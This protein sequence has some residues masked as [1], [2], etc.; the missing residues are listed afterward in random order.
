MK[1][2]KLL[3]PLFGICY[4]LFVIV[5]NI[6]FYQRTKVEIERL[7]NLIIEE[8]IVEEGIIEVR[9]AV[10]AKKQIF[11]ILELEGD[12]IDN[13]GYDIIIEEEIENPYA[14]IVNNFSNYD[15]E[16]F[17]TILAAEAGGESVEGQRMAAEVMLNRVLSDR[18]PNTIQ[19]VLSAPNQFTTWDNMK[20]GKYSNKQIEVL[21]L[22]ITE[23]PLLPSL[24]YVYFSRG[25][26]R[27][28]HSPIKEGN[29]W[30]GSNQDEE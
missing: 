6:F 21:E 5:I 28:M 18:H 2:N 7:E 1:K 15:F 25:I 13:A 14:E 29:H 19:G 26:S 12:I 23:D 20:L 3:L 24:N 30:F 11:F 27:Y 10:P 22:V 9:E 4:L 16:V 8:P 17:Y